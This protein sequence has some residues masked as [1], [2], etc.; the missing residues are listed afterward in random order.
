MTPREIYRYT[1]I[2]PFQLD[3]VTEDKEVPNPNLLMGLELEIENFN[4]LAIHDAATFVND[5]SLRNNGIEAVTHVFKHSQYRS[6]LTNFF[7]KFKLGSNNY[8]ERCSIHVH[9]NVQDMNFS[10]I[11][12]LGLVYQ[13]V[14]RLLF[15][16]ISPE[17]YN[18]IFCVPWAEAGVSFK[19]VKRFTD[20]ALSKKA[21][22][23]WYKYTA[24]N[25]APIARQGS[26][27][28][29]HMEGT[30]DVERILTWLRLIA[31]MFLY[32]EQNPFEKVQ[33]EIVQ[34]NTISNYNAWLASVFGP[35]TKYLECPDMDAILSKGVVDSK[36]MLLDYNLVNEK[37]ERME[38][39]IEEPI[40]DEEDDDWAAPIQAAV[41][42]A[43]LFAQGRALPDEW[44]NAGEVRRRVVIPPAQA[45]E[46]VNAPVNPWRGVLEA[47]MQQRGELNAALDQL[48]NRPL[49]PRRR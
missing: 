39:G 38:D 32:A 40:H 22:R 6:V 10:K 24:L 48:R 1:K 25:F 4:G 43:P 44:V 28:F 16:F 9:V 47:Q 46:P 23:D 26:V 14:E 33:K 45:P 20:A 12:T 27:E 18:N 41:E 35:D 31:R 42:A 19:L 17:R 13:T 30:A 11:T 2:K 5:G 36:C 3:W 8:S 21:V 15:N 34:M 49:N 29:R 7:N 37:E